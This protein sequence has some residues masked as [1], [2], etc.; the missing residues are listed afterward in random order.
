MITGA[1]QQGNNGLYQVSA[2][3]QASFPQ[4]VTIAG[5]GTTAVDGSLPF[6]QNQFEAE[7][8]ASASAMKI[9]LAVW[10]HLGFAWT[11]LD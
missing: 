2:V 6:C 3:N 4:T 5:I 9:D 1:T 8:G 10:A 7:S 11:R